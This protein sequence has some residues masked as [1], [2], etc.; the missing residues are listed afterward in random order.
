MPSKKQAVLETLDKKTLIYLARE[1]GFSGVGALTKSE[2]IYYLNNEIRV[3]LP[4]MLGELS[5]G[6]L[7]QIIAKSGLPLGGISKQDQI[8]KIIGRRRPS[9]QKPKPP[10]KKPPSLPTE[11]KPE[12]IAPTG[13]TSSA[14]K[15]LLKS[16]GSKNRKQKWKPPT[17]ETNGN[18]L[19]NRPW[20]AADKLWANTGLRPSEFSTPVLGLI[21]LR[22]AESKFNAVKETLGEGSS[23]R[24]RVA[25]DYTA[26]SGFAQ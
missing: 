25:S 9:A 4:T 8:N 10:N 24:R 17:P 5:M 16:T 3:S 21:F 7:K 13:P 26:Y 23:R 11:S 22:C 15:E 14:S 2:I 20:A 1:F 12:P 19:E 6:D 18:E